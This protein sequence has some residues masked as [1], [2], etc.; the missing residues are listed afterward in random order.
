MPHAELPPSV[1]HGDPPSRFVARVGVDLALPSPLREHVPALTLWRLIDEP[2]YLLTCTCLDRDGPAVDWSGFVGAARRAGLVEPGPAPA[3][4]RF[5]R[6]WLPTLE[7][8]LVA[9]ANAD[10]LRSGL[11]GAWMDGNRDPRLLAEVGLWARDLARWDVVEEA[12]ILLNETAADLDRDLL[13]ALAEL[14]AEARKERPI[15]TWASAAAGAVLDN[16]EHAAESVQRR[17][18]LDA[19]ILHA[20]WATREDTDTAVFAGSMR[21]LGER[22]LPSSRPGQSLEAA[23]RTKQ[24][25]DT[26][27]DER[28]RAGHGPG[29][30]S[31]ALF[32]AFSARLALARADRPGAVSE[33]NWAA[34][35]TDRGPVRTLAQGLET[36][37]TSLLS[38]TAPVHPDGR[39]TDR[40]SHPLGVRSLSGMGQAFEIL[41]DAH[42][43]VQSLDRAGLERTLTAVGPDEAATMGVW[44]IRAAAEAFGEALWGDDPADALARLFTDVAHEAVMGREQDEPL[45]GALLARARMLLLTKAGAFS[46]AAQFVETLPER[47]GLLPRARMYLWAGQVS[48]ARQLAETGP[49]RGDL[50][51]ADRTKL[52][53]VG[54][55]AALLEGPADAR[56]RAEATRAVEALLDAGNFLPVGALPTPA[57]EAIVVLCEP[58]LGRDPRFTMMVSRLGELNDAGG[59]GVRPVRLTER[60]KVLLPLLATSAAVPEIARQLHVSVNTVRK[61]VV[62]LRGKFQAE[63]RAEL[64]RRARTHGVIG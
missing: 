50:I 62:T 44:A 33:A 17:M 1:P 42:H 13:K 43:A 49:Y 25:V 61:Q 7:A 16:P 23:W 6:E 64:V 51:L 14:P 18:S 4:Y 19:A 52:A 53:L 56:L 9:L 55:G 26:L 24:E 41:A 21:M 54:V 58:D 40:I 29:R 10:E 30:R 27:I 46:A 12:W 3:T 5:R 22:R 47:V 32:R 59:Q 38:E 57:R 35:L 20:D 63:S 8:G 11:V 48:R 45:G 36:I 37:A 31:H 28:S 34:I 15:L 39:V 2:R 60:E